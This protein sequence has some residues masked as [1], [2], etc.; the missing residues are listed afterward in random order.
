[1]KDGA[2]SVTGWLTELADAGIANLIEPQHGPKPGIWKLVGSVDDADVGD[3]LPRVSVLFPEIACQLSDNT[4]T[5]M[6]QAV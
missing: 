1:M 4:Q 3:V 2:R 6:R 5:L